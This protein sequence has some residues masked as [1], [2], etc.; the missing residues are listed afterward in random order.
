MFPSTGEAIALRKQRERDQERQARGSRLARL[1]AQVH[2]PGRVRHLPIYAQGKRFFSARVISMGLTLSCILFLLAASI[3][4]FALIGRHRT[5]ATALVKAT[6]DTVRVGD[7]F[8]LTGSGFTDGDLMTFT[9]DGSLAV[10][11]ENDQPINAHVNRIGEF[12]VQIPVSTHWAVG[13][14]SIDALDTTAGMDA[15]T[16]IIVI[17]A[18]SAAPA[19]QLTQTRLQFPD[20]AA[21]V[22]SSQFVVL[23]NNG[24]GKLTWR[25]QSDQPWLTFSPGSDTFAGAERVQISVNRGNLTPQEYIGHVVFTQQDGRV[26]SSTLTVQLLIKPVQAELAISTTSLAYVTPV[27]R[28]PAEQF[29]ILHNTGRNVLSWSS[30]V[31]VNENTSWLALNPGYGQLE[32]GGNEKIA[33]G[34]QAQHLMPGMYQGTIDFTGGADAQVHINLRVLAAQSI[35]TGSPVMGD[36]VTTSAPVAVNTVSP[37]LGAPVAPPGQPTGGVAPPTA[38]ATATPGAAPVISVKTTAMHFSTTQGQ[39]PLAQSTTITN[40]GNAVV[41]WSAAV[42]GDTSG[43]IALTPAQGSLGV[44]ER[45]Q[46]TVSANVSA[47][48][49][50]S[51]VA[52]IIISGGATVPSQSIA[53]DV[54]IHSAQPILSVSPAALTCSNASNASAS[55]LLSIANTGLGTAHWGIQR[56]STGIDTSWLTIS[57]F[58]GELAAGQSVNIGISCDGSSLGI[59]SYSTT[60]DISDSD[61]GTVIQAVPVT[62]T[63]N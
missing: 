9:Y 61:A 21:G 16:I 19:L 11:N 53:V 60:V 25:A 36:T 26:A 12:S 32:P 17:A 55:L 49:S 44:G 62:F 59:G 24:G 8:M 20:A 30:S 48:R 22:V 43:A 7:V 23:K 3:I 57:S 1:R 58:S 45:A 35:A 40:T 18:S 13:T 42:N 39:N 52:T 63:V 46:L 54:T 41:Q 5:E 37:V 2:I 27:L 38:P 47:A 28:D 10:L 51:L 29:I 15:S 31:T 6:P 50:G 33:V 34:I 4:A 56:A 14:H